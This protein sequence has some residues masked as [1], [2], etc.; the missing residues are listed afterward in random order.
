MA[1]IREKGVEEARK[2]FAAL[3]ETASRGEATVITRHG[4]PYA[5]II[6]ASGITRQIAGITLKQLRGSGKKF[7]RHDAAKWTAKLRKEWD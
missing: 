6:P 5:A 1:Q 7:W 2:Q 4:S 3:L